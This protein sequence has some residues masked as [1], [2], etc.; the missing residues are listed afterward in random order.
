MKRTALLFSLLALAALA[1]PAL[2]DP[3]TNETPDPAP[4][5]RRLRDD[6]ERFDPAY[7]AD[8]ELEARRRAERNAR[9]AAH[10]GEGSDDTGDMAELNEALARHTLSPSLVTVTT[11]KVRS[12][13]DLQNPPPRNETHRPRQP[14]LSLR[15]FR[16]RIS[17]NSTEIL[18]CATS[19]N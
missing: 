17:A 7:D 1:I 8:I 10:P 6:A 4:L 15:R 16:A 19:I 13:S 5:L 11:N 18:K 14:A 9:D 12:L 2:A 3:A